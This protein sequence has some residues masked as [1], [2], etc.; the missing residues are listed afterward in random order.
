MLAKW[1]C[2]AGGGDKSSISS[3]IFLKIS[4]NSALISSTDEVNSRHPLLILR[5]ARVFQKASVP[6]LKK[7]DR[8]EQ[9]CLK[10]I[11][12]QLTG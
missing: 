7:I 2:E 8:S 12:V 11:Y 9:H 3:S 10:G 4:Q 1:D 5:T 6:A